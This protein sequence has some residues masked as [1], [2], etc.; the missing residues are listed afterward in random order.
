MDNDSLG[1]KVLGTAGWLLAHF[2]AAVVLLVV[3]VRVV[4]NFVKVFAEF[5]AKLPAFTQLVVG[6]SNWTCRYWWL[7]VPVGVIDAGVLFGLRCL[8]SGARWLSTVWGAL[9]L[10]GV[11]LLLGAVLLAVGVPFSEFQGQLTQPPVR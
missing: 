2:G 6:F 5:S 9:V 8:P 11:I 1:K 7:I 4:P 3:L 10:L